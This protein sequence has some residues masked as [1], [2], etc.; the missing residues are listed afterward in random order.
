LF[1]TGWNAS[2]A[3]DRDARHRPPR[4]YTS[5]SAHPLI[6]LLLEKL[7]LIECPN[8]DRRV[9]Q[10]H[11]DMSTLFYR[12]FWGP[13]IHHGLWES[14]ESSR[15]AQLQLTQRLAELARIQPNSIVADIG[16]GMGG[17]SRWLANQLACQVTGVTISPVQRRWAATAS[18]LTGS[19]PRPKFV[20]QDAEQVEFAAQSLDV[21]WSIECTEHLYEKSIFFKRAASWL[22]PGG[23]FA[24][25]AWLAGKNEADEDTVRQVRD[26]CEG[27]FCPSLGSQHDYEQWLGGSGMRVIESQIWTDKVLKTWE[28]CLDRV[29]RSGIRWLAKRMGQNHILFLDR[30]NAIL[31]AYKSRAME[32]GCFVAEKME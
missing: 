26:V 30:F 27:M 18:V 22:K 29:D 12:L 28:I 1:C 16:C 4:I 13:H 2:L 25:C 21:V 15:I 10:N 31:D 6:W 5:I 32:Y 9:I 23:R 24:I 17:S 19:R 20:C 14:N 7:P 8:I 11:Y 3:I